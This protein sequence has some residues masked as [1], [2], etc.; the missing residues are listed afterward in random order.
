MAFPASFQV[1]LMLHVWGPH[2]E[3]HTPEDVCSSTIYKGFYSGQSLPSGSPV[4]PSGKKLSSKSRQVG[5]L[6]GR[7]HPVDECPH[8]AVLVLC[9]QRSPAWGTGPS[10]A[11]RNCS[12]AT[13]PSPATP[14]CAV[15]PVPRRPQTLTQAHLAWSHRHPSPLLGAPSQDPRPLQMLRSPL[16]GQRNQ[17]NISVADPRSSQD[18]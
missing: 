3:N 5:G 13:A 1:R 8:A 12:I 16:W 9:V 15:S 2:L 11:S 4:I 14:G 7:C 10:S 18:L 17:T 6:S